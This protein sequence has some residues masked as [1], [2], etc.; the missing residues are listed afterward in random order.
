MRKVLY[1]SLPLLLATPPLWAQD[2]KLPV[3]DE[4]DPAHYGCRL[5]MDMEV[6]LAV[7]A[8]TDADI[9]VVG[10]L[11]EPKSDIAYPVTRIDISDHAGARLETALQQAAGLQ[12]FRRSDA[13]SAN[14][15]SQGITMRGLGGNASS[16]VVLVL[17]DVPQ[18]DPF[19]GWVSWP[20]YDALNLAR[21]TV[22]RGAGQVTAG[23]GALGGV[24]ELDSL[25]Y[26]DSLSSR[27]AYGSR[28]SV[29]AKASMLRKLG[30][31]SFSLSGSY[32][33]GDGFVPIAKGQRGAVDR[34]APY[35]QAGLALRAVAPISDNTELQANMRA[36]TDER[37]RG[38][39]FSDSQNSGVDASLRLV[40]RAVGGWQ[41]S[42]LGYV[43]IREFANR[44]G[45]IGAGRN[46]VALTLDQYSVP[47]TG[48]GARVEVRPP[49]GEKAELRL[50]GDWRRTS[51]ETN[52]NFF[53]TGLIPGRSRR[54]GG[55]S[56]VFG[57][58]AEGS[59]TPVE[60]VTLTLGGRADRWKIA[61]GFR[62]EVNIGGSVRSDDVFADRS[63]WE[64]TGRG[65]VA[66]SL[67][68]D[69]KLRGA[70]YVGWRLPTLN[71]LYRPF[72]VGAD[73][74]AA[75]ELLAPEKVRGL[76]IGADL[77]TGGLSVSATAFANKLKNA[78]ANIG[79]GVGPGNFPGVGFVAAG[80]VYRQRQN[81]DAIDSKGLE[82]EVDY[83]TGPVTIGAR[84]AYVDAEVSASSTA[85][86]LN[87]LRPAQVPQHFASVGLAFDSA[88]FR[89]DVDVRYVG[90]QFE[91]DVNSRRLD[92]ALTVDAGLTYRVADSLRLEL[93]GENL[94]DSRVEAAIG[95]DGVIERA[96]PRTLSAGIRVEF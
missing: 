30:A 18:A 12:Q 14:P 41:W 65:S 36:F 87:G 69:V 46:S 43:Q 51:G 38:F 28:D 3:R 61:N 83:R 44:F 42:A 10:T 71:E 22:R 31:G 59:Y 78:I 77:A 19:G 90:G 25:Q 85:V 11:S 4:N 88:A 39:D 29:D 26:R 62:K 24:V 1:F 76:E 32:A 20:G 13:R 37:D 52:E 8:L 80:G 58:F 96:T 15:T 53:F 40:N 74:T 70:A 94:L 64:G 60:S 91:D 27:L 23:A 9:V 92:D 17:D 16:R 50:G 5:P 63:G 68:D 81:L 2:C 95:S 89:T 73:A 82:L 66:L 93:R 21:V 47:S 35:E 67:N 57:L 49:L 6:P 72:R 7:Q 56:D 86:L 48:L 55:Q 33:R 54:A 84:Y 34:P 79:L 45:A 75:N